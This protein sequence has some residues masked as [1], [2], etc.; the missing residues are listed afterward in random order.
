MNPKEEAL[1]KIR[2]AMPP[3][4]EIDELY[5]TALNLSQQAEVSDT[6]VASGRS[7]RAKV[8]AILA[9]FLSIYL[10]SFLFF[11]IIG[12][13]FPKIVDSL[14]GVVI[15]IASTVMVVRF[16]YR[17]VR[18]F[19]EG[20]TNQSR[21]ATAKIAPSIQRIS[22]QIEQIATDNAD[23]I[24]A[25]PRDYRYYEAAQFFE[26]A[27]ENGRAD[28][29]KEAVNLYEDNLHKLRMENYNHQL[30]FANEQQS[31][32]LAEIEAREKSIERTTNANL[33]FNLFQY[34]SR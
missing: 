28:N 24:S 3:L 6:R 11:K 20:L 30:L 14:V 16:V 15:F 1:L 29:M 27:L 12:P 23:V 17:F 34:L 9:G 22:D 10:Y 5:N 21:Q 13:I 25:M 2:A 4:K 18:G 8:I 31:R 26:N 7:G 33:A 32:M 19:V